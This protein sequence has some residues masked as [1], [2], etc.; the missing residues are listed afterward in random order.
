MRLNCTRFTVILTIALLAATFAGP[1]ARADLKGTRPN[2]VLIMCDDM[3]F[4][5]L[6]CYGGEVD[7]PN[8]DRL[9]AEGMKFTQFYNNAKCTTTRASIV[10][11]LYPRRSGSLLQT[12]MVTFGEVLKDAGYRTTLIG[13]W[14]LGAGETTYPFHRGFEEYY[15]LLDGCCNYFNP[16]QPDPKYKGG[17]VRLFGHNDEKITEFPKDFYTTNAFT[18]H[19]IETIKRFRSETPDKPFLLHLTYNAPHY[20]LHALPEDIAKYT[21]KFMMGWEQM[22]K[23][24]YK[25]Q[26]E[27]GLFDPKTW[28]LSGTDPHAYPWESANKEFE[29]SR[30]AV[31]AAM[32]DRMDQNIGRLMATIK[33]LG[34]DDNTIVMFLSDNGGCSEEPGGR[35][36]KQRHPGPGDDY[37]AVGPAWGWAQN[38]PFRRFKSWTHEGGVSTPMIV[39]WPGR[40]KPGT[41]TNQPGHIIDF[42]PTLC[43]LAGTNYPSEFHG[44]QIIPVEGISLLPIFE[45]KTRK[46]HDELYWEWS[47]HRAIR[48]GQ[49]K[50]VWERKEWELYDIDADRTETHDLASSQPD[51]VEA[52]SKL[53]FVWADKTGLKT[54]K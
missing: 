14:H 15:G 31:Y 50:L 11:G 17:R 32:I 16:V 37:V 19:A 46:P 2:I 25:R 39:R 54:K 10:T 27:M 12:S 41:Q 36:P 53:W 21:G 5:D 30:M 18:D 29:D 20:P 8:I 51:R 42:M 22:R 38:A 4:S 3:G 28:P 35:D 26:V 45:G 34:I 47:G 44:N 6:H 43:D 48:Q 13:K 23:D 40:V 24:R 7:T 49:W 52:M 33:D 9:A 1:S